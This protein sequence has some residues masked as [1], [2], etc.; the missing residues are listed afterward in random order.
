MAERSTVMMQARAWE[1]LKS[2]EPDLQELESHL[3][4]IGQAEYAKKYVR[5]VPLNS[6][7]GD[8]LDGLASLTT[9]AS[10]CQALASA[11]ACTMH[12]A[13]RDEALKDIQACAKYAETVLR[14]CLAVAVLIDGGRS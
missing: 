3:V 7:P 2:P 1:V 5:A 9:S 8:V 14:E 13:T 12:I 4:K 6:I 11:A 10:H